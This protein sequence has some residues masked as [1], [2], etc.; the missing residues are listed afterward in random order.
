M[1]VLVRGTAAGLALV[2]TLAM[3]APAVAG[4]QGQGSAKGG[5]TTTTSAPVTTTTLATETPMELYRA[6][7]RAY[8]R[9]LAAINKAF[10]TAIAADKAALNTALKNARRPIQKIL[11][12]QRFNAAR[13][14]AVLQRQSAISA[15]GAKPQP[16]VAHHVGVTSPTTTTTLP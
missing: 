5:P 3:A 12:R 13:A 2:A 6:A 15:L 16:P 7:L 10:A 8:N 9:E 14:A 4:A 1:R 11:A